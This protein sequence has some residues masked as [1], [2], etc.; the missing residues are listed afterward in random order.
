[1]DAAS[2]TDLEA[3][4]SAITSRAM[5]LLREAA[6]RKAGTR[7]STAT[8]PPSDESRVQGLLE[9]NTLLTELNRI[10]ETEQGSAAV[11]AEE[12]PTPSRSSQ[13][14]PRPRR[15]EEH[16]RSYPHSTT[17]P[18]DA[19]Q[20]PSSQETIEAIPQ[21]RDERLLLVGGV[22]DE[23]AAVGE[24]RKA[25]D[26]DTVK[27]ARHDRHNSVEMQSSET[28][29]PAADGEAHRGTKRRSEGGLK[30]S[31]PDLRETCAG[32]TKAL[33]LTPWSV[34]N[35]HRERL[36]RSMA[37]SP[38]APA[39]CPV[40]SSSSSYDCSGA[41][42][43]EPR[44]RRS[45][46]AGLES[47]KRLAGLSEA[48]GDGHDP[49]ASESLG[50]MLDSPGGD[51]S[52]EA[53][54]RK[55]A[56]ARLECL[57]SENKVLKAEAKQA[58]ELM[59]RMRAAWEYTQ[60]CLT[61]TKGREPPE[62]DVT[63]IQARLDSVKI[64]KDA[65][66]Q[67]AIALQ[68]AMEGC[69]SGPGTP[70]DDAT[71]TG[72]STSNEARR[73]AEER[74]AWMMESLSV[75]PPRAGDSDRDGSAPTTAKAMAKAG[76]RGNFHRPQQQ[77]EKE[78][79]E[80]EQEH[81]RESTDR[82]M[83]GRTTLAGVDEPPSSSPPPATTMETDNA[84]EQ[85]VS[86]DDD[87]QGRLSPETDGG[88]VLAARDVNLSPPPSPPARTTVGGVAI[89]ADG[90][91]APRALASV[92][93][94]SVLGGGGDEVSSS[95]STSPGNSN[96]MVTA[97]TQRGEGGPP[98]GS[99]SDSGSGGSGSGSG[100]DGAGDRVSLIEQNDA[101]LGLS[102]SRVGETRNPTERA[103]D[104]GGGHSGGRSSL[105][106]SPEAFATEM[107]L[108][109]VAEDGV[110]SEMR[111]EGRPHVVAAAAVDVAAAVV[112]D[113]IEQACAA[114][115]LLGSDRYSER[116]ARL[117]VNMSSVVHVMDEESFLRMHETQ[118]REQ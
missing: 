29:S 68:V 27:R 4:K 72:T 2:L 42:N 64:A 107:S 73:I 74:V 12:S 62:V 76:T 10:L 9:R 1:M 25:T 65:E 30:N 90:W 21:E 108:P 37:S 38:Q 99:R 23:C 56:A 24:A 69:L 54:R 19:S 118:V 34:E 36:S 96:T 101:P 60:G 59:S 8:A 39:I 13:P 82:P 79:D 40:A 106:S 49:S 84:D 104:G 67:G 6:S 86:A 33:L 100:R 15:D 50:G 88:D 35:A 55:R 112:S 53:A 103:T 98:R 57:E 89:A 46:R 94:L 20:P 5:E 58:A 45:G 85:E 109:K 102:S 111:V 115:E 110:P 52:T 71:G 22:E 66:R 51:S 117:G 7:G 26:A 43:S 3:D 81:K 83:P 87:G 32:G 77:Q 113:A 17:A 70:R 14:D 47:V 18:T 63:S 28:A 93:E 97:E 80:Q 48:K 105:E 75:E 95:D 61:A 116:C 44:R 11:D 91:A 114:L 41:G 31:L 92:P 78:E 16:E